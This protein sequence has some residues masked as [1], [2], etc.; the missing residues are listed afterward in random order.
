MK[1]CLRLTAVSLLI[2]LLPLSVYGGQASVTQVTFNADLDAE[3]SIAINPTNTQNVVAGW[4]SRG[5]ATCGYGVSFDG[6]ANWRV[7]VVPGVQTGSGG[8]FDRGTD[9]SVVFDARGNAYFTCLAYN[10]FPPGTGS[11][12]TIY[13]SKSTDGG[14]SW[15]TP[16][17]AVT[18]VHLNHFEDHQFITAN[19]ATGAIYL[20]LTQFTAFGKPQIIFT[21]STD[22]NQTWSAP[23]QIND[24][25]GNATFQDSFTATGKD[26][27]TVYLTFGAFA[28]AALSNWNRIYIA[29]ST[30]GGQTFSSPQ[31][32]G[33]ITP[34]PDPLPNA[35]WRSDNNLWVAVDRDTNQIYLNYADYNA[36][37]ADIRVMRV[38]DAGTTFAVEGITRV[39][40]DGAGSDQ[41]FPF[42]TVAPGGR[43]DV[44]FQDRRYSPG[45][46]LIY[47]T[48]AFSRDGGLSFANKQVTRQPFDASNNSFLGDYNWQASTSTAVMPI[49]AGDGFPT[50]DSKAQEIF[51]AKVVP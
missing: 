20:S 31:L 27:A 13:V 33:E 38:R 1:M 30:D 17:A 7:G 9:P 36:G 51:V 15:A 2:A 25:A 39:N 48:C 5:D 47:T 37:D 46:A 35:P 32:L 24:Y 12:G 22:G 28:T 34:L 26:P 43:V 50:G 4:I 16:V 14:A 11:P 19:P 40:D 49:F 6:G 18:G 29:K 8:T 44:C 45:N 21:R 42:V 23:V 3:T 41:F 10:L